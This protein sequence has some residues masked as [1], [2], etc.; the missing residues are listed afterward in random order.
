MMF[1]GNSN[2]CSQKL[3]SGKIFLAGGAFLTLLTVQERA[4]SGSFSLSY[5]LIK[6]GQKVN[7]FGTLFVQ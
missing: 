4:D 7:V 6:A 5:F 2:F 1:S 3:S